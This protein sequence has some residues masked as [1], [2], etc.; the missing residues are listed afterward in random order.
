MEKTLNPDVAPRMRGVVEKCNFCHGRWHAAQRRAAAHGQLGIE[1]GDYV[2]ACVEACPA[3]AI[4]FGDLNDLESPP[5]RAAKNGNSFRL[6]E[7]LGTDP[8]IYYRSKK[9]WVRQIASAPKP[10]FGKETVRG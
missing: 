5:A 1:A 6:L 2:P 9:D 4:Q 3:G 8:K 10:G 7:K